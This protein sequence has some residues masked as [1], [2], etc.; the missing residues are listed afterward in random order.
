MHVHSLWHKGLKNVYY[1]G[2]TKNRINSNKKWLTVGVG[3]GSHGTVLPRG[4]EMSSIL[5]NE[6]DF[7]RTILSAPTLLF[8]LSPLQRQ[9]RKFWVSSIY[10][11]APAFE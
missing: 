7:G 8:L 5:E 1:E 11:S 4:E 10:L 2:S 3:E 9:V 6:Y